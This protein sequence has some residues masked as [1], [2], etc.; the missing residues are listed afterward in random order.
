MDTKQ[1]KKKVEEN[2]KSILVGSG[3]GLS[4]AALFFLYQEFT[5]Q[6]EFEKHMRDCRERG[7][8]TWRK[9]QDHELQIDRL[10]RPRQ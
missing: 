10:R 9:V 1:I 5:T 7:A 2:K 3:T 6:R 8:E 4:T